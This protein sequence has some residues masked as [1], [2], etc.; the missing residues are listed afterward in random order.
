MREL[1]TPTFDVSNLVKSPLTSLFAPRATLPLV[2]VGLPVQP[3]GESKRSTD[4][5]PTD[6]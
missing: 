4:A 1:P 5:A 6:W 3:V 2:P